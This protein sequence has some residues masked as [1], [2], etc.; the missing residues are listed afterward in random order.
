MISLRFLLCMVGTAALAMVQTQA[1]AQSTDSSRY[2]D[3]LVRIIVTSPPGGGYDRVARILQSPLQKLLGQSVVVENIAGAQGIIGTQNLIRAQ[4]DG[5]HVML[6][7]TRQQ[8]TSGFVMEKAP[9]D[10]SKD[11][12]P[13]IPF[14]YFRLAVIA[15]PTIPGKDLLDVLQY[16]KANPN[17]VSYANVGMSGHLAM[18]MAAR[19]VGAEMLA[20]PYKTGGQAAT[21]VA[22]G[23]VHIYTTDVATALLSAQM[24][25][26]V[27]LV[28]VSGSTRAGEA[29]LAPAFSESI[30]PYFSTGS[31]ALVGPPGMNPAV[32]EKIA[33]AVR[34][35]M[36]QT[37]VVEAIR[38]AGLEP[39]VGDAA[40]LRSEIKEL[41]ARWGPDA[42][43][44]L[45]LVEGMTTGAPQK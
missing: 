27:R 36:T 45:A 30:R 42:R 17:K 41:T 35:A 25:K 6:M 13:I 29:P 31:L 24:G 26:G 5:Y 8:F 3:R 44:I 43:E 1:W 14:A 23:E 19:K 34:Q 39:D 32:V 37:E 40:A 33:N 9:Y 15:H 20:V 28:A 38:T 4:P 7:N 10:L 11:I 16:A 22:A 21:A 2:P 18:A 12:T